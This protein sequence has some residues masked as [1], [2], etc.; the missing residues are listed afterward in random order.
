MSSGFY[1][2]A[3]GQMRVDVGEY[4]IARSKLLL[5]PTIDEV[6]AVIRDTLFDGP[7]ID[8]FTLFFA[9]HGGVKSGSFY[10]LMRDSRSEALSASALSL[11]DFFLNLNEAAPSQS[12]IVID[13]C[14]SGGLI[15]DL[16]VLLKSNLIGDANTPGVTLLAMSAKDQAS[17]E[18]DVGG[19]GTSAVLD[20]IEGRSFVQEHSG[21]LDLVEIG[22][23]VS[24][25]LA[26]E[27]DQTPVVW[28]LNLYGPPRFCKNPRFGSDPSAPLRSVVQGWPAESDASIRGRFESLWDLVVMSDAQAPFWATTISQAISLGAVDEAEELAG[29]LFNSL[30]SSGGMVARDDLD[31]ERVLEFLM[32]KQTKEVDNEIEILARP[33]TITTVLLLVARRLGLG[34]AFDPGLWMLDGESFAAYVNSDATEWGAAKMRSGKYAVWH[35]GLDFFRTEDITSSWP[36]AETAAPSDPAVA[37]GMVIAS[38]VYPDRVAWHLIRPEPAAGTGLS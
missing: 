21:A 5:S 31:P 24:A 16:G 17:D 8:T 13:A 15:E 34:D 37:A 35:I 26:S 19:L 32:A 6:R 30:L 9:G 27:S 33:V 11:A 1:M 14:E 25:R 38:L 10:M 7:K 12:N 18:T 23:A 3:I 20:V 29:L 2:A 4:D 36:D 22:R 28:G